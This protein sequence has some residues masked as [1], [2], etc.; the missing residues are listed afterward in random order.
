ML[1]STKFSKLTSKKL[2]ALRPI[3]G[4]DL[5][6]LV[7]NCALV[8]SVRVSRMRRTKRRMMVK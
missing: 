8:L 5:D 4:I 1:S 7:K 2:S 6:V 3:L